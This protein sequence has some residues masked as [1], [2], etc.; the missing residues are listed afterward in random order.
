MQAREEVFVVML[1]TVE[2]SKTQTNR[3]CTASIQ[4]DS[5]EHSAARW[6]NFRQADFFLHHEE[7]KK[8]LKIVGN[9]VTRNFFSSEN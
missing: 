8:C 5:R 7:T 3:L 6:V 2:D 9:F 4:L 1:S